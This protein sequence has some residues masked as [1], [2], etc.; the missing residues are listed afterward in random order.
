MPWSLKQ[1]TCAHCGVVFYRHRLQQEFCSN[2]CQQLATNPPTVH[3]CKQCGKVFEAHEKTRDV[4]SKACFFDWQCG[5]THPG[6]KGGATIT[7]QGYSRIA[8]GRNAP[9]KAILEHQTIAENALGHPLP[10]GA[11]VHHWDEDR[12][13]NTPSNL[14]IC[15]DHAYHMLLHARKDRLADTGSL[16][17]KRCRVCKTVKPLNCFTPDAGNWD[18]RMYVC[19]PCRAAKVKSQNVSTSAS[20]L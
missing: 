5:E 1:F 19:K 10:P 7:A 14:V 16:E 2:K 18:G 17:L 11:V 6:W 8:G 4:C 12:T 9:K 13:N 3:T 15:Q 20:S